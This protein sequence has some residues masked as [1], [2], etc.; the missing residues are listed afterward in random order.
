[1][2]SSFPWCSSWT[3]IQEK[4]AEKLDIWLLNDCVKWIIDIPAC[5]ADTVTAIVVFSLWVAS[6]TTIPR[7]RQCSK[8]PQRHL[9]I[10]THCRP[11]EKATF[12]FFHSAQCV[13]TITQTNNAIS[14][15]YLQMDGIILYL[16]LR[17]LSSDSL[18]SHIRENPRLQT[19]LFN[20][21][22]CRS[23]KQSSS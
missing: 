7:S 4:K 20:E 8:K 14:G 9:L 12:N 23:S 2:C 19:S 6:A 1:M 3:C 22:Y 17:L 16:R 11:A 15:G 5:V 21:T 13:R 10:P 18:V